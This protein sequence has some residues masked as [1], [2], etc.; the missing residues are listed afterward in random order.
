MNKTTTYNFT[1]RPEGAKSLAQ[2]NAL[3]HINIKPQRGVI[4]MMSPLQ[5]SIKWWYH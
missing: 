2:G 3:F 5:G 4:K 1:P